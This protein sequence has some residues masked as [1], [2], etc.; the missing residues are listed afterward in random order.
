MNIVAD[1]GGTNVRF[2]V[3]EVGSLSL[4]KVLVFPCSAFSSLDEAIKHYADKIDIKN[5]SGICLAVPGPVDFNHIELPNNQWVV[6]SNNLQQIFDANISLVNDYSAQLLSLDLLEAKDFFWIGDPRPERG[7]VKAV[8][9]AGTGFG[10]AILSQSGDILPSEAGH[11]NFA[12][13]NPHEIELLQLLWQR[14]ERVSVERLLSGPGLSN[15]YWANSLLMGQEREYKAEEVYELIL[16]EDECALRSLEDFTAIYGSVAGDIAIASGALGGVY[17]S[18]GIMPRLITRMNTQL[19]RQ[20]FNDK[21]R[22]SE[23]CSKIPVALV[24]NDFPG[25]LGA[26]ITMKVNLK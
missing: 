21:G 20:R 11:I 18:G 23:Y 10:A 1:I 24:L 12:P 19:F 6:D 16:Q 22:F 14:Y 13:T 4:S 8:L 25:L 3:V 15:L 5:I 17:L 2:A 26:A 9:G 7:L